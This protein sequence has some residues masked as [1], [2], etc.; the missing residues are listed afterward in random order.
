MANNKFCINNQLSTSQL[1]PTSTQLQVSLL[2]RKRTLI[3]KPPRLV[4]CPVQDH[5]FAAMTSTTTNQI[6]INNEADHLQTAQNIKNNLFNLPH[7]IN[8]NDHYL[9]NSPD[10]TTPPTS[11][12]L[13]PQTTITNQ[14]IKL[15]NVALNLYQSQISTPPPD[16]GSLANITTPT[17]FPNSKEKILPI[18]SDNTTSNC[19]FNSSLI[20]QSPKVLVSN[21]QLVTDLCSFTQNQL[22]INT[23][24]NT[25][26]TDDD[27]ASNGNLTTF[28]SNDVRFY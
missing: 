16:R 2:S 11:F 15:S 12:L 7:T 8:L 25:M 26:N 1:Q 19:C 23:S 22:K 18:P 17:S 24:T 3:Y 5:P 4:A 28:S 9:I 13:T 20:S 21:H 27:L 6:L 14:P 10:S